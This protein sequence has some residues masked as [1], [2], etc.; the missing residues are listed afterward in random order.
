MVMDVAVVVVVLVDLVVLVVV[1]RSL[2][3]DLHW[4]NYVCVAQV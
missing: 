3:R 1:S 2:F 4:N